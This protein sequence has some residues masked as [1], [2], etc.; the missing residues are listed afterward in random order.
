[1]KATQE[2]LNN[3]ISDLQGG[4]LG[5]ALIACAETAR[6]MIRERVQGFGVN[7]EGQYFKSYSAGYKKFKEGKVK[8]REK[9]E[10]KNTTNK[11]QGFTDFSFTT[12]MWQDTQV[13]T[14]ISE[15]N[16]D[17]GIATISQLSKENKDKMAWNTKSFGTILELSTVEI[18]TLQ[19]DYNNRILDI[20]ARNGLAFK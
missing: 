20:F 15:A 8:H 4:A 16:N 3:L 6:G 9:T 5:E 18:A 2:N 11:Y 12:R 1:M 7:A 19:D 13:V 10:N 17:V 14:S